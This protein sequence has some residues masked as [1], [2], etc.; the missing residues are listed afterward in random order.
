MAI[1]VFKV[2]TLVVRTIA[3]PL[4]SWVT[5]YNR[6]KL[7]EQKSNL[8]FLKNKI[9]WI[10]QAY[11]YYNIKINRSLFRLS[12]SDPIKPLSEDKAIEKGAEFISEFLVYSILITLPVLEWYRQA[13][14]TKEA[15]Y[16]KD[17]ELRRMTN[18]ILALKE[19]NNQIKAKVEEL[20]MFIKEINN[21]L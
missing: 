3:K 19:Q 4:I 18:D 7:Q 6:L 2:V 8:V 13:K 20:Q 12:K 5:Y 9:V 16:L 10:G 14:I 17:Q 15:D 11:N 21:K 1:L